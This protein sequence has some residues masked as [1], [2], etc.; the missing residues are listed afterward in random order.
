MTRIDVRRFLLLAIVVLAAPSMGAAEVK[1]AGKTQPDMLSAIRKELT[2]QESG[3]VRAVQRALKAYT[4]I[5]VIYGDNGD[6]EYHQ[7][8]GSGVYI[9]DD[10]ILTVSHLNAAGARFFLSDNPGDELALIAE[11]PEMDL[12]LLQRKSKGVHP[13]HALM[14]A[15]PFT[16]QE[17][18]AVG[19]PL[20]AEAVVV[21]GRVA[22]VAQDGN[23][24]LLDSRVTKGFSGG[25]VY[26]RQGELL[27][28]ISMA[29]G[30]DLA[31]F[32][33]AV[34]AQAIDHFLVQHRAVAAR[35]SLAGCE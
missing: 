18:F 31:R 2:A 28:I 16:S 33:V 5:H 15:G 29:W 23:S 9:G 6:G 8:L 14:A 19:T 7:K 22:Q 30:D 4:P 26:N 10:L 17:I 20:G 27:G 24:L 21:F 32:M 35:K 12:M 1:K 11:K 34:S 13:N 3:E 25:G